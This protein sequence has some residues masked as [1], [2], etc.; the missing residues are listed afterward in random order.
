MLLIAFKSNSNHAAG[1]IFKPITEQINVVTKNNLQVVA[2]SLK[3]DNS[4]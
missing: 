3:T 1:T 4:D 2:G